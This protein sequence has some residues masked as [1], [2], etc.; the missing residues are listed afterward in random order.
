MRMLL[1]ENRK[2]KP[3]KVLLVAVFPARMLPKESETS[4]P[5]SKPVTW[6]FFTVTPVLPSPRSACHRTKFRSRYSV[7][8][9]ESSWGSSPYGAHTT[10]SDALWAG[11][12]VVTCLG[13]TFAGRVGGGLLSA[14]G[15]PEL[16]TNSLE[17]YEA[18]ALELARNSD[19]LAKIRMQLAQ[20][21][22]SNPLFN[23]DRY[24]RHLETAYKTMW[25][26]YQRGEK[27]SSFSVS[28]ATE[29]N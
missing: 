23:T 6:L 21:R 12:P 18:K 3:S 22:K 27:P 10:A 25:D 7:S 14:V 13:T 1:S 26:R 8:T 5:M 4:K 16:V 28:P 2:L 9:S 29:P 11:L 24:T 19:Q 15:L 17:E 20:D